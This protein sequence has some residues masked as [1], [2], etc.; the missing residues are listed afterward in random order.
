MGS[1]FIQSNSA[2][3]YFL[4]LLLIVFVFEGCNSQPGTSKNA[5]TVVATASDSAKLASQVDHKE[6]SLINDYA[7]FLAGMPP[8]NNSAIPAKILNNNFNKKYRAEMDSNF[9]KIERN[10]L[11]LMRSWA[12]TELKYEQDNLTT[13]FYPFS[14][15]DILHALAFY[16]NETQY[17]MIAMERPGDIPDLKK[18]D[19]A[20]AAYYLNSVFQSLQDIFEKS[21]FITHKMIEDLQKVKVNGVTPLLCVFLERS[22]HPV[23]AIRK[24]HLNDDGSI[25]E[26]PKDSSTNHV[27]DFVE[28]YFRTAGSDTLRK[29]TYF[30]A[31]LGDQNFAGLPS[32]K[33]N[34]ALQNYLNNLPGFYTYTKSASYLMNYASFSA[35]RNICLAKSKSILQDDTGIGFKFFDQKVWK[36]KLYGHYV[37]PVRDFKGVYDE[38]LAQAY[39]RDSSNVK[40]LKFSLGYHWGNQNNQNLMKAERK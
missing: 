6:D 9:L 26:L 37:T 8:V 2:M 38:N 30:R 36:V 11:R 34:T 23:A 5:A 21:Y 1:P 31:N 25:R 4:Q 39:S 19:S 28:I 13:L 27:N 17:V 22:G 15:P 24:K 14:G 29:I 40:P 16:P 18:M 20:Q 7:L 12:Q 10:R 33:T 35:I 32:F 3:R